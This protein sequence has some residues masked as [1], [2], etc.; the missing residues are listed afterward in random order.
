MRNDVSLPSEDNFD[1]IA[2]LS[3][4]HKKKIRELFRLLRREYANQN[5]SKPVISLDQ[6]LSEIKTNG[7]YFDLEKLQPHDD[8]N[9]SSGATKSGTH[10]ENRRAMGTR[11]FL[12]VFLIMVSTASLAQNVGF[13][14]VKNDPE[15]KT[16]LYTNQK[17][18]NGEAISVQFPNANGTT[19]CCKLTK[20]KGEKLQQGGVT[21]ILNESRIRSYGLD[22]Q[23]KH[24]FIGIAVVSKSAYEITPSSVEIRSQGTTINTCL[25]EEGVHLL[26]RKNGLMN[27]H[28][29]LHL[30]YEIEPSANSCERNEPDSEKPEA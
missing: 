14:F 16:Y 6:I 25:S 17:I 19:T 15:G 29:Y 2:N 10:L 5:A 7:C 8:T 12:L 24:P 1:L 22:I 9:K 23:Y 21:D 30:G 27:G 11:S 3:D 13:G 18:D 26:S 4:Q 28:L 20:S